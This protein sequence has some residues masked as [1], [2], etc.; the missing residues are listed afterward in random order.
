MLRVLLWGVPMTSLPAWGPPQPPIV[1]PSLLAVEI[2]LV[3]GLDAAF[4][5]FSLLLVAGGRAAPCPSRPHP[6]PLE[7]GSPVA[8]RKVISP[9]EP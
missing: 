7:I 2:A 1:Y 6:L 3:R 4:T 8:E 5:A 9:G